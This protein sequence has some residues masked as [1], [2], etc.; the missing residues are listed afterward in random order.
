[1][2][3]S[4]CFRFALFFAVSFARLNENDESLDCLPKRVVLKLHNAEQAKNKGIIVSWI[5]EVCFL[6]RKARH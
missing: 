3:F 1:M 2:N 4:F 6:R 5:T